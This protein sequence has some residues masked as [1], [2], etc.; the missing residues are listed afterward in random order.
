MPAAGSLLTELVAA[1]IWSALL[2]FGLLGLL[3]F[4][5]PQWFRKLAAY[6]GH[7]IDTS[8]LVAALDKRIDIDEYVL[9]HSRLLGAVVVAS[10]IL[11][12]SVYFCG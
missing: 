10:L 11:L 3:A 1:L 12:A 4:L 7:W 8:K 2:L 5:C 6:S 9:R